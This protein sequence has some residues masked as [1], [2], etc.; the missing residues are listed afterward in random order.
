MDNTIKYAIFIICALI[1]VGVIFHGFSRSRKQT[2]GQAQGRKNSKK[3]RSTE[4]KLSADEEE[5]IE[6]AYEEAELHDD[7]DEHEISA[8]LQ[9]EL[10][11][12]AEKALAASR[13]EPHQVELSFEDHDSNWQ[14]VVKS[15]Y[16][17]RIQKVTDEVAE[18]VTPKEPESSVQVH[19]APVNTLVV[20]N[21]IAPRSSFFYG[22]DIVT[23]LDH[24]G[25]GYGKHGIYHS[26]SEVDGS[27]EFCVASAIEPGY[28]DLGNIHQ[29]TTTGLTFFMDLSQVTEPKKAFKHMLSVVYEVAKELGGD[30]LDDHRQ[31]LTQA[32]V[33]EYLARIK[34]IETY[35]KSVNG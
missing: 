19:Y 23:V 33:S 13:G 16:E 11:R 35:R 8:S 1:I 4:P 24:Q 21:V 30:I 14:E 25:L 18:V 10:D 34:G 29:F 17:K 6:Q 12:A 28:F 26:Y 7:S 15:T 22:N 5:E 20:L 27:S 9:D 31:R 32:S 2:H 3:K